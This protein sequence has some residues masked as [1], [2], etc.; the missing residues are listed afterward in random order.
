MAYKK[1][2]CIIQARM[3]SSRLPGK[4]LL[5]LEGKPVLLRVIDRVLESKNINQVVVATTTNLNDQKIVDLL[6]D[7]HSKV[8]VFRGSE[9]DVLDRY[10]QAAKGQKA[11]VVVRITSDCPLM[12]SEVLDKVINVFLK[13]KDIDYAS[14]VFAKRTF[15][16]GLDVEVFS[17][18]VLE[19]TWQ[20]AENKDDREHVTLYIRKNPDLFK[21]MNVAH[22]T[23][24]SHYRW[25]L[26]E[27]EDYELIKIIY[28]ELY[29]K[30]PDFRMA[31]IIELFDKKPELVKIN[32]HVEQKLS[33]F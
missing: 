18:E 19:K 3:G 30:N 26:D 23:D 28:Q 4:V 1:I 31:D 8:F 10:Y 11:D 2:V 12:D 14:N 20:E 17:F 7:Y 5:D 29:P 6:K 27:K 9:E 16:R 25:T 32:Q 13:E 24:Y 33:K 15:P 22:D 21:C